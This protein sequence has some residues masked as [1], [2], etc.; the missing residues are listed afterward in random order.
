MDE[1][2]SML[3]RRVEETKRMHLSAKASLI[4]YRK[5]KKELEEDAGNGITRSHHPGNPGAKV[6]REIIQDFMLGTEG[7]LN[8]MEVHE[9]LGGEAKWSESSTRSTLNDLV[10]DGIVDKTE[11]TPV[12]YKRS[13]RYQ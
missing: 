2:E 4:A 13:S 7:S 8:V 9:A 5:A 3:A 12:Y 6:R 11:T 10:F 1:F